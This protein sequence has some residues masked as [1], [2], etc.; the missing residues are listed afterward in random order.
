MEIK[1]Y[2]FSL[3]IRV[4]SHRKPIYHELINESWMNVIFYSFTH[5]FLLLGPF[6]ASRVSWLDGYPTSLVFFEKIWFCFEQPGTCYTH[7]HEHGD[8]WLM[9]KQHICET[10]LR[11]PWEMKP[12]A[13]DL[14]DASLRWA[15]K[16]P[17]SPAPP[18]PCVCVCVTSVSGEVSRILWVLDLVDV[19][20]QRISRGSWDSIHVNAVRAF[21]AV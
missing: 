1:T 15:P 13:L 14:H 12:I 7:T 4:L 21:K 3:L 5:E 18:L 10:R 19:A 11:K 6:F 9:M 20:R 2:R 8:R 17:W 16:T